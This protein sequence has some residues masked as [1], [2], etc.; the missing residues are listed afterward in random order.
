MAIIPLNIQLTP[1]WLDITSLIDANFSSATGIEFYLPYEHTQTL[2]ILVDDSGVAIIDDTYNDKGTRLDRYYLSTSTRFNN[3]FKYYARALDVRAVLSI[4]DKGNAVSIENVEATRD[5]LTVVSGLG[6][7]ALDAW[8]HQKMVLDESLFS[9]AFTFNI[10][11]NLWVTFEDNVEIYYDVNLT[12]YSTLN[13]KLHQTS[14]ATIGQQS[15]LMSRR[16]ARYQP[17][18]GHLYSVSIFLPNKSAIGRRDFGLFD[19]FNGAFFSLEDGVLY[20]VIRT[21]IGGVTS[22][23]FKQAIDTTEIDKQLVKNGLLPIDYEKGNIYDIQ[24]QWRGVGDIRWFIGDPLKKV[25]FQVAVYEHLNESTEL[26]IS[27]PSL[28]AAYKCT[29]TNGTE[30]IIESGCVDV[31][32]EGGK[33]GNRSYSSYPSSEIAISTLETPIIALRLPNTIFGVMNTRD[34]VLAQIDGY[35]DVDAIIRVYYFRDPTAITATFTNIRTGFQQQATDGAITAFDIT[36][37]TKVFQTRIPATDSK[38]FINPDKG[39]ADFILTHGD[40][41]LV[42][43]QGKNNSLGGI[44]IEW[45]EEI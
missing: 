40:Y 28:P 10:D 6:D 41:I 9:S 27:N 17:N 31:T 16:H 15:Y 8:G 24:M 35:A 44:T 14:G 29:N 5:A 37:M 36:K 18:R 21:T 38:Q 33:Q 43:L 30:V 20:A 2:E 26:S 4:K 13:G 3:D 11:R 25:S 22:E 34:I 23:T 32:T 39:N 19:E 12:R 7:L 1:N 42:T 45:A